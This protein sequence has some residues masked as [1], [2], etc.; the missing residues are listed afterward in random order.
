MLGPT[1]NMG[2][3]QLR[4]VAVGRIPTGLLLVFQPHVDVLV[5]ELLALFEMIHLIDV[6]QGVP[7]VQRFFQLG[8]TPG[9][10]Q[11]ALLSLWRQA[12]KGLLCS[13]RSICS[14]TQV[15]Q[16]GNVNLPLQR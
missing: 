6:G 3:S 15:R 14:W 7:L 1:M 12:S 16:R 10:R 13:G 5:K 11:G 2:L 9:P 8:G 4:G